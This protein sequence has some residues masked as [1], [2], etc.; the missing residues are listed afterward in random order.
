MTEQKPLSV[1][2]LVSAIRE[3]S[4][5]VVYPITHKGCLIQFIEKTTSF[6]N[7]KKQGR[8]DEVEKAKR[9]GEYSVF[10][11]WFI[12]G[13]KVGNGVCFVSDSHKGTRAEFYEYLNSVIPDR[14]GSLSVLDGFVESHCK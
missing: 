3:N 12:I 13:V 10:D 9:N 4:F 11:K 14:G 6:E 8:E 5:N 1:E 7:A 2:S